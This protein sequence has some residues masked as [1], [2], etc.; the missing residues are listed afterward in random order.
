M[1]SYSITLKSAD[2]AETTFDCDDDVYILDAAEEAGVD[3][4]SSCRSGACSSCAMKVIE[5]EVNQ[6][7]QTFLDEEQLEAGY[8]LTCVAF[9]ESDCVLLTE[10]E[11]NLY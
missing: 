6:E 10:Q 8:V 2:G 7:D 5:G 3:H 9:P 11:E 4:P 1:A